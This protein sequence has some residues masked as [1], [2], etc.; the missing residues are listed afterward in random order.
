MQFYSIIRFNF[1][2][3]AIYIGI[4]EAAAAGFDQTGPQ[5]S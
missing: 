2:E 5:M 1:I 3:K 4:D